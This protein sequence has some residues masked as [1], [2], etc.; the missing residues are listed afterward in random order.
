M[1]Y[2][3]DLAPGADWRAGEVICRRLHVR[4]PLEIA[5]GDICYTWLEAAD[6]DQPFAPLTIQPSTRTL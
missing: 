6:Y 4:I 3:G 2:T 5:P 1:L